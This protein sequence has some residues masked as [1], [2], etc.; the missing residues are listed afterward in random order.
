MFRNYQRPV[1]KTESKLERRIYLK[2]PEITHPQFYL[3]RA[4]WTTQTVQVQ[5]TSECSKYPFWIPGSK[6]GGHPRV[7]IFDFAYQESW[8]LSFPEIKSKVN[9]QTHCLPCF[10]DLCLN[11]ILPAGP[12]VALRHTMW[13][14]ALRYCVLWR[15]VTCCCH[16]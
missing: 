7:W 8:R 16:I 1:F 14:I 5:F 4:V 9:M 3:D 6:T 15:S 13:Q 10:R 12:S 2:V 11:S